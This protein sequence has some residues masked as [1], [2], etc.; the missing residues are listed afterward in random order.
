MRNKLLWILMALLL[1]SVVPSLQ[2]TKVYACSCLSSTPESA[3]DQADVIFAGKA[4]SV[5]RNPLAEIPYLSI[6]TGIKTSV[7]FEVAA[8]WKGITQSQAIV[9]V[10]ESCCNW[11][12]LIF[13]VNES[14][15][16]YGSLEPGGRLKA[17][18]FYGTRSLHE[19]HDYLAT[20]GGSTVPMQKV[21]LSW[22]FYAADIFLCLLPVTAVALLAIGFR[23]IMKRRVLPQ[24]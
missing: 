9:A 7:L 14:Y 10:S 18:Y 20:L 4:L 2:P 16:V 12:P 15:L 1:L 13:T 21:D 6:I 11:R 22:Q 17:S 24:L 19:A 5:S 23:L 8:T 3:K